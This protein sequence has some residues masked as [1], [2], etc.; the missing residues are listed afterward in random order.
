MRRLKCR[1]A[2]GRDV[3]RVTFAIDYRVAEASPTHR[4]VART[5]GVTRAELRAWAP[6]GGAR[7][8]SWFDADRATVERLLEGVDAVTAFRL[9]P[10]DGGTYAFV[11]RDGR[12]FD[13]RVLGLVAAADVAFVPPVTFHGSGTVRADA[14]GEPGPLG[15]FHR[16]LSGTVDARIEAVRE[17]A[18]RAAPP[19]PTLT[20]RRARALSV[21]VD[22][23]YYDV[24]RTGAVADVADELGCAT[25]TAG[26]LLRR[27]E[28]TLVAAYVD[29]ERER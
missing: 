29:A 17:F 25:S 27:A 6:A 19:R 11:A 21:A 4:A 3:K 16:R 13:P 14:V 18:G 15:A 8:L 2:V 5:E 10:G 28:A 24:P 12:E 20:D 1:G 9:V 26:E 7:T 22:V 23:G